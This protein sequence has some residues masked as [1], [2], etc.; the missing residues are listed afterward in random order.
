MGA[1]VTRRHTAQHRV[2][3]ELDEVAEVHEENLRPVEDLGEP[4]NKTAWSVPGRMQVL[5]VCTR[6]EVRRTTRTG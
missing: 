5:P 3:E 1:P 4:P 2:N 6:S